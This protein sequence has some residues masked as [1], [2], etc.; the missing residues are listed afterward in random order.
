MTWLDFGGQMSEAKATAGR[1]GGEDIHD[2]TST[3]GR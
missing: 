2:S 1:Q 3:L